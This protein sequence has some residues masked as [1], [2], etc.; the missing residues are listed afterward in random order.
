MRISDWS[1][2]VCSSDLVDMLVVVAF[3]GDLDRL[4]RRALPALQ[5]LHGIGLHRE[6]LGELGVG[7]GGP[8]V[9]VIPE[10]A[11]AYLHGEEVRCDHL[12]SQHRLG[13]ILGGEGVTK[14]EGW[15]RLARKRVG[16]G[17]EGGGSVK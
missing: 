5:A 15:G 3:A 12:G 8:R 9:V 13:V 16:G 6:R 4:A 17:T 2:D 7:C 1:S 11:S 14:R 10:S